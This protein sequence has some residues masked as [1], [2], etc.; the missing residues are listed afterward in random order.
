MLI[1][2]GHRQGFAGDEAASRVDA[3]IR[4]LARWSNPM[5]CWRQAHVAAA[6]APEIV[7]MIVAMAQGKMGPGEGWFHPGESRYD[8]D[9]L[10]ARL[11]ADKD[12][13]VSKDEFAVVESANADNWFA[14]LDRNGDRS[15]KAEDLD[16]S[17][18]SDFSRESAQAG[19]IARAAD[20]SSNGRISPAE[21]EEFYQRVAQGKNYV[22]PDDLRRALFPPPPPEAKKEDPSPLVLLRGLFNGEI[23]SHREGPDVGQEAPSFTLSTHD[24]K[25]Q[26]SLSEFR[27]WPVVIIFGSFT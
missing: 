16:W 10:A 18:K 19:R 21:W 20:S 2:A 17:D 13:A 27:D 23:G 5:H 14:T 15:I 25:Q 6:S 11:D 22:T 24:G 4:S 12:G 9:W 1:G 3:V 7:Q 8:W 26:H